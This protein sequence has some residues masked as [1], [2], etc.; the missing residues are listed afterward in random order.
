MIDLLSELCGAKARFL[1]IG[2]YAVGVHGHPR[3]TKDLD[4]WIDRTEPN[5]RRV[6]SALT[7][8]GAPLAGLT[9]SDL[10][11]PE[12]VFQ[13]GVAPNRVDFL[14]A[15]PGP[16][17]SSCYRRR[18]EVVIGGIVAPVIGRADLIANKRATGR[19]QDLA[20]VEALEAIASS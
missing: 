4:L 17:F 16:S 19:L 8:F 13:I 10:V 3:A 1:V 7:R 6:L 11:D 5:A 14:S 20:D 2:G 15:I 9:V 18:H 12:V